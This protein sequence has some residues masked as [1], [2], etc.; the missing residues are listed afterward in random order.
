MPTLPNWLVAADPA[1]Q[2]AKGLGLGIQAGG[3]Q[4]EQALAAQRLV[5]QQAE[6]ANQLALE[7]QRSATR[8]EL[9]RQELAMRQAED[10]SQRR[11]RESEILQAASAYGARQDYQSRVA[12]GEDPLK[13]LMELGPSMGG[14]QGA[15]AA[16]IRYQMEKQKLAAKRRIGGEG[17]L[18]GQPVMGPDGKPVE[19]LIAVPSASGEGYTVHPLRPAVAAMSDYQRESLIDRAERQIDALVKENPSLAFE[20]PDEAWPQR[21]KDAHKAGRARIDA[22]RQR[23]DAL[24]SQAMGQG[25]AAAPA[26]GGAATLRYDP[27]TGKFLPAATTAQA[28]IATPGPF[29]M[30]SRLPDPGSIT[31]NPTYGY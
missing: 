29:G 31:L 15:E 3:Q 25:P 19:G 7:A 9:A 5:A 26:A 10:E 30:I 1:A 20:K 2:Y 13:V 14:Q 17:P 8:D 23:I 4:A 21:R 11:L 24:D 22:L 6:A 28:A 16:N 12:A 18:Q 27:A